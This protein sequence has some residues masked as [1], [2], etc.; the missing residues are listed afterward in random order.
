MSELQFLSI[1][2]IFEDLRERNELDE[3]KWK[4]IK[5][6]FSLTSKL[7]NLATEHYFLFS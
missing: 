3:N 5:R 4:K 6:E 1:D 7:K 2:E